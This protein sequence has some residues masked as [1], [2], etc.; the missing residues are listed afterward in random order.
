MKNFNTSFIEFLMMCGS[1]YQISALDNINLKNSLILK[2]PR[3]CFLADPF[4]IE[5]NNENFIFVEEYN[6]KFNKGIISVYKVS[7]E[8]SERIGVAIEEDFHLS[9]PFIFKYENSYFMVPETKAKGEI[10]LYECED[11]PLKWKFKKT[12]FSSINAT[13][14]LSDFS[15]ETL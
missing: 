7:K 2:N 8:K 3:N 9:F 13:P 12:I 14:I 15:F 6:F 10:R 4:I 11:F 1:G 5:E